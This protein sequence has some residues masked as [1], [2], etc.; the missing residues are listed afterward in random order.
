MFIVVL[1]LILRP[2][3]SVAVPPTTKVLII[4]VSRGWSVRS[5]TVD[6]AASIR[7]ERWRYGREL[8]VRHGSEASVVLSCLPVLWTDDVR[9]VSITLLLM[10]LECALLSRSSIQVSVCSAVRVR[11][12]CHQRFQL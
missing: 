12:L 1:V 7:R 2:V 4:V 8:H 3:G 9:K 5:L 6:R 11:L 10:G